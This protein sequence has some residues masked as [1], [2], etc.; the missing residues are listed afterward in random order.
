MNS[1]LQM[2]GCGV[3]K[4]GKQHAYL[5]SV[6]CYFK[7]FCDISVHFLTPVNINL[8]GT[9]I[10]SLSPKFTGFPV[11]KIVQELK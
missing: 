3:G 11:T 8:Q 6:L 4:K 2:G 5:T 7:R 10:P 9:C 1:K